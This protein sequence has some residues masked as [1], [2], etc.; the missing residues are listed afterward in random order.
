Y[1]ASRRIRERLAAE[2]RAD[3]AAPIVA[4]TANVTVE[5]QQRCFDAGMDRFLGKPVRKQELFAML[6][7]V[8]AE[9]D[10][11]QDGV[12]LPTGMTGSRADTATLPARGQGGRPA[13]P[14]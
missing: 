6:A 1:E 2:G 10:G 7:E 3:R 5:D 13:G 4:V 11:A 8:F 9:I 14:R 12:R